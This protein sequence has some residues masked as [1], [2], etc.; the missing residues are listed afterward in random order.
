MQ[1]SIIQYSLVAGQLNLEEESG[2]EQR[3]VVMRMIAHPNYSNRRPFHHDIAIMFF[4]D[5]YE[6]NDYVQA[7]SLPEEGRI[8]EGSVTVSGWGQLWDEG[9][10]PN[11]LH[12]VEIPV[13]NNTVCL[14]RW[15]G[16]G[17]EIIEGQLCAGE[18]TGSMSACNG[19]TGGPVRSEVD[20]SLV[21]IVSWG[22]G[23]SFF[24]INQF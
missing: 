4:N 11:L 13:V 12:F 16:F 14:E 19:D 3:R 15:G 6:L 24:S 18:D 10:Y 5:N 8:T 9:P 21:G 1:S 20:G 7:K 17:S 23:N 22:F 2:L